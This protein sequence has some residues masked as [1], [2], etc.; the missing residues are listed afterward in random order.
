M[1][2]METEVLE[3]ANAALEDSKAKTQ[4]KRM[5]LI[6]AGVVLTVGGELLH[7]RSL[8]RIEIRF[9]G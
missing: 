2:K 5:L 4:R 7:L 3:A 8:L 9:D 6:L 1:T